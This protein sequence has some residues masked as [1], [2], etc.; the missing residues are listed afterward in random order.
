MRNFF[1]GFENVDVEWA[2]DPRRMELFALSYFQSLFS[3]SHE[4]TFMPSFGLF[5]CCVDNQDNVL[6][7][8]PLQEF[9]VLF[10]LKQ[11][12]PTKGA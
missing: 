7:L 9:E 11:M 5:W 3:I 8:A 1:L 6:L 2:T 10:T 12:H 4:A